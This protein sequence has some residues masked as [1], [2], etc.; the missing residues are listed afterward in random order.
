MRW[1]SN[2]ARQTRHAAALVEDAILTFLLTAMIMLAFLQIILRNLVE[3]SLSWGD[4]MLRILVL[5]LALSGAIIA[6]RDD[7]HIR[8]DIL[9]RFLPGICCGPLKRLTSLVSA[10]VC[11][12]IAWYSLQ[13]VIMEQ[14]DGAAAFSNIPAWILEL[15]LPIGFGVMAL[16]FLANTFT[17]PPKEECD[18]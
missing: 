7:N 15:I 9:S 17:A 16:H 14:E 4:P 13:F 3:I 18:K 11:G 12:I 2:L 5:W 10:A 8:I 1:L 6:T